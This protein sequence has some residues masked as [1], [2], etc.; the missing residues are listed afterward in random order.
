MKNM[1]KIF[2][3]FG[4]GVI[5]MGIIAAAVI[6][7]AK[8]SQTDLPEYGEVPQFEFVNQDG[9][10]YGLE[11]FKGKVSVLDFIFTNCPGPCPIMSSKMEDLY[12]YYDGAEQVQFIS[13]S[14]DPARDTLEALQA[15]A[16]RH[17]VDDDRWNFLR[18][19]IDEVKTLS[20]EGFMLGGDFPM[21]HSTKFVLIDQQGQIRGYYRSMEDASLNALKTHIEALARQN[22]S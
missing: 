21:G 18:A 20:V 8:K 16:V 14:V 5:I 7:Q 15:Y 9:E 12:N 3:W 10:P 1:P 6:G 13:I 17:S 4:A 22:L 2:I 11:D 19:P